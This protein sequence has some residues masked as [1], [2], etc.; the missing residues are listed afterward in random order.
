MLT[1]AIVILLLL[2]CATIPVAVTLIIL[3]FV[4]GYF[5][6]D[7]P[8]YLAAGEVLWT[9]SENYT[10]IAIPLFVLIG[11]IL[12]RCG[13]A[14]KAYSIMDAWLSWLPG[15]L[16]HANI[17][18]SVLFSA[19]SGSSVATAA[20]ISTIALPEGRRLG[21]SEGIFSGA[22]AAG[23]TLGIL[24][25][26][27]ISLI[28]YGI[29]TETSIPKLFAAG[30]IPGLLLAAL[31]CFVTIVCS[32]I[33]PSISGQRAKYNWKT[34]IVGLFSLMPLFLL[35]FVV[36]GSI[37]AGLATPT[38]AAAIGV[39]AAVGIA[40]A[41]RSFSIAMFTDAV[42][43]SLRTTA[44]IMLIVLASYF[45]NFVLS[46]LG[47]NEQIEA[48][49]SGMNLSALETLLLVFCIYIVLGMFIET[50]SLMVITLPVLAP[51][52]FA[53]GFDKVW[54]GV[55]VIIL[56]EMALITPPVGL[57]LYVVQGVRKRGSIMDIV[58]GALPYVLAMF[59]LLYIL[60]IYPQVAL[61]LPNKV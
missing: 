47:I 22:V 19:T 21:Y 9:N 29:F 11:E 7:F 32:V 46:T 35:F 25:P 48:L 4:L 37:Y 30:V 36:V 56:I 42:L 33:K 28:I 38:E 1:M 5:Y 34:R 31:F 18:A 58:V 8:F 54:F 13:S 14:R 23:G 53:Q 49:F 27:S 2:M 26:P 52:V 41:G 59:V 16:I 20:T 51:I 60:V 57:N 10:L 15:G 3:A 40:A 12:V 61:Y 43:G 24:I 50:L 39:L 45:L 44:M 17:G 6:S 55:V